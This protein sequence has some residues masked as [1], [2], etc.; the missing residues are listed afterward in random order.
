MSA[1]GKQLTEGEKFLVIADWLRQEFMLLGVMCAGEPKERLI[2][3]ER[4]ADAARDN[5]FDL[6]ERESQ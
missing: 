2:F 4:A 3:C 1:P 6:I 5:L